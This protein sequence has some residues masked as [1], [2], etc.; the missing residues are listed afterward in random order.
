MLSAHLLAMQMLTALSSGPGFISSHQHSLCLCWISQPIFE[1]LPGFYSMQSFADPWVSNLGWDFHPHCSPHPL[2]HHCQLHRVSDLSPSQ[3]FSLHN[4]S[5]CSLSWVPSAI[6]VCYFLE[7]KYPSK[8][9]YFRAHSS[10]F[11]FF[12]SIWYLLFKS[13]SPVLGKYSE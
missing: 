9:K 4:F 10:S 1:E 11:S 12:A 6:S 7:D 8:G 13:I 5:P 2:L 3:P